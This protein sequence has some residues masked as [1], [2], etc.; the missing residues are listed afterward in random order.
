VSDSKRAADAAAHK[1]AEHAKELR[2][3]IKGSSVEAATARTAAEK[4][5]QELSE[6]KESHEKVCDTC[7]IS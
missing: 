5:R 2:E 1:A 4:L 6:A 3:Q 7:D